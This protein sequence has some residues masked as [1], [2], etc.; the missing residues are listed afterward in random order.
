MNPLDILIH[1][2]LTEEHIKEL[3]MLSPRVRISFYPEGEFSDIPADMVAKAE[4]M[5]TSGAIPGPK[6]APE[7]RWVQFPYAGIDFVKD[8][9]LLKKQDFKATT[10]SGA[11]SPKIAEYALMA[12]LALGHKL[13]MMVQYQEKKIWP[14]DRIKRFRPSE[15]RGSTVGMLGYGSIARELARMLQPFDVEILATKNDLSQLTQNGYVPTGTGDPNGEYFMRIYPPQA[16]H[17]VLKESDFVIVSL[18][19]TN[20][21]RNVISTEEF[22]VM[23]PSAYLVA[24]GRGGQVDEDALLVALREKKIAG[25]VLDVFK[26][27]P[28]GTESPLWGAPNLV[29]TPHI[30]GD[31]RQYT[32]MVASLF[33][34]NLR[35]YIDE[36]ELLNVFDIEKGY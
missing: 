13:P 34:A 3:S 24:I 28:L 18:P 10:L 29:I 17:S 20:Q 27:E 12:L 32:N 9:P 15:L 6:E 11:A 30:A 23:K 26:S 14:P 25:A 5:L 19:L 21:T 35:R 4:I 33:K 1:Y 2:H 31:T 8:H 22:E 36:H 16:T 7:L